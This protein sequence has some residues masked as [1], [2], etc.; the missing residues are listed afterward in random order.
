M[1]RI[2]VT[3]DLSLNSE[4]ALPWA[5]LIM[6]KMN[7]SMTFL[8]V[9]N[10]HPLPEYDSFAMPHAMGFYVEET[11]NKAQ[12]KMKKMLASRSIEGDVE[13]RVIRNAFAQ[14][15]IL[16]MMRSGRFDLVIMATHGYSSCENL[17]LGSVTER[18]VRHSTIPILCV[19]CVEEIP[20]IERILC[21]SDFSKY[22]SIGIKVG[23]L[24]ANLFEAEIDLLHICEDVVNGYGAYANPLI[25]M[26]TEM[27]L[28]RAM[29]K[30]GVDNGCFEGTTHV[31]KG[32]VPSLINEFA[33]KYLD[34]LIVMSSH[35]HT[36]LMDYLIGSNTER[37]IR[38][39]RHPVL[40]CP[41]ESESSIYKKEMEDDELNVV[42]E[43]EDERVFA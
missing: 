3:T 15:G 37:V 20:K 17:L 8:C 16:R 19:R 7:A 35:G 34:D 2:L 5:K 29:E 28:H 24:L 27:E 6:D 13:I 11:E 36:G 38:H 22:S 41:T 23:S 1:T 26:K 43:V 32:S 18:V 42:L 31:A 25:R 10:P 40:V 4:T 30:F 21:P 9:V 12:E 33:D 39:G 14:E